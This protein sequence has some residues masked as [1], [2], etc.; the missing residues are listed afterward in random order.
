MNELAPGLTNQPGTGPVSAAQAIV[1]FSHSGRSPN[2]TEAFLRLRPG[3]QSMLTEYHK[4][5]G[6]WLCLSR[7][8]TSAHDGSRVR[9]ERCLATG[10]GQSV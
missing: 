3:D 1:S 7:S 9:H 5:Y 2:A 6:T 8:R 10:Q 4:L